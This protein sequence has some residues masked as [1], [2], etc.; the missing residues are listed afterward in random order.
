MRLAV[1]IVALA[2]FCSLQGLWFLYFPNRV[3]TVLDT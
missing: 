1:V 3:H 2:V